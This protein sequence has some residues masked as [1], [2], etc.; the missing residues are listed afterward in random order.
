MVQ[1]ILEVKSAQQVCDYYSRGVRDRLKG[2]KCGH[3]RETLLTLCTFLDK[4]GRCWPSIREMAASLGITYHAA[5]RRLREVEAGGWIERIPRFERNGR[6]TTNGFIITCVESIWLWLRKKRD[7]ILR[8]RNTPP[9]VTGEDGSYRTSER[10]TSEHKPQPAAQ[11]V[12]P[13]SVAPSRP[14]QPLSAQDALAVQGEPGRKNANFA[15]SWRW[16]RPARPATGGYVCPVDE[17]REPGSVVAVV[18][19]AAETF[20]SSFLA[21]LLTASNGTT[22][23]GGR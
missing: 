6:Q 5:R 16:W 3:V 12:P 15:P 13:P 20:G 19:R 8:S 18:R 11:A 2:M 17:A 9:P 23:G 22:G 4:R 21:S 14:I 7:A 10:R 1:R